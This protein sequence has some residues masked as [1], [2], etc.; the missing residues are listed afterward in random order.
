MEISAGTWYRKGDFHYQVV[1]LETNRVF[2]TRHGG[3]LGPVTGFIGRVS[4]EQLIAD[5]ETVPAP[6]LEMVK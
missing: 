1:R 2:Y 5:A 6:D 3:F 4:F